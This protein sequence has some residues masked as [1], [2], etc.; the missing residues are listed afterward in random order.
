M[1]FKKYIN[2]KYGNV[3]KLGKGYYEEYVKLIGTEE[4]TKKGLREFENVYGLDRKHVEKTIKDYL[5]RKK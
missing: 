2:E 4:L 5:K 3:K 1:R